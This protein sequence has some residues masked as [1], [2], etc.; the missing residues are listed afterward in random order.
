MN[1]NWHIY[2]NLITNSIFSFLAGIFVIYIS[3]KIFRI[4]DSR[5]KLFFLMLPFVKIISDLFRG[6]PASSLIWNGIDPLNLPP[7]HKYLSVGF[8]FSQFCPLIDLSL[9][10]KSLSGKLYS[11]SVSDFLFSWLSKIITPQFPRILIG[12]LLIISFFL[13]AIKI[14]SYLKFEF[15]RKADRYKNTCIS[16]TNVNP[17]SKKIDIYTSKKYV[18]TPF[19]GGL[20]KPFI[21]IPKNAHELLTNDELSAVLQHEV[22][23]VRAFDLPI[24]LV[25]KILGDLFWF[26][27]GYRLLS[28]KIDRIREILADKNAIAFGANPVQLA[29]ALIKL[30]DSETNLSHNVLYSAFFKEKSLLKERICRLLNSF[31]EKSPRFGWNKW[32]F[33]WL[34]SAW[35]SGCVIMSTFGGNHE[36]QKL[37]Q[38]LDKILKGFGII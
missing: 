32:Y 12:C 21:C 28:R 2:F 16:L 30:K 15:D 37:P 11:T 9:S 36:L 27:P 7:K 6:I 4:N 18:G 35:I 26:V 29:S 14:I 25:I 24:S 5:W 17:T 34:I 19:T 22:A 1:T 33:R 13:L 8:G 23:H 20:F 38:W 3:F 10:V 31:Q